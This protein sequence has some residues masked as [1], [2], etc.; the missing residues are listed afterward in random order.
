M[1]NWKFV[2]NGLYKKDANTLED[3]QGVYVKTNKT[4]FIPHTSIN[5]ILRYNKSYNQ[6]VKLNKFFLDSS[7]IDPPLC[8][9]CWGRGKLDWIENATSSLNN[10]RVFTSKRDAC[11]MFS[12]HNIPNTFF[13]KISLYN[14]QIYCPWCLGSGLFPHINYDFNPDNNI[15]ETSL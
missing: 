10:N 4:V 12:F 7:Y 9:K 11:K 13:S 3:V 5:D 2:M 1:F 15:I 6:N 8:V 14:N